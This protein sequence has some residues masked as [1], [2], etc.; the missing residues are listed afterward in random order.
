[1][2]GGSVGPFGVGFTGL[3]TGGWVG[4][5]YGLEGAGGISPSLSSKPKLSPPT[6]ESPSLNSYGHESCL[7]KV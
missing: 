4:F 6:P 5:C 7:C 1:M 2:A 3:V